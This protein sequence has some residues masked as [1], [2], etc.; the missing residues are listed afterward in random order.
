[1][2][3]NST[4]NKFVALLLVVLFTM[5]TSLMPGIAY[6]DSLSYPESSVLTETYKQMDIISWMAEEDDQSDFNEL[7]FYLDKWQMRNPTPTNNDLNDIA[8]G[9]EVFV[10]VGT[11][12]TILVSGDGEN[13]ILSNSGTSEYLSKVIYVNDR[14]IAIGDNGVVLTSP[15]GVNWTLGNVGE[16]ANLSGI[17]YGNGIYL[18]VSYWG[19]IYTSLDGVN[20]KNS[21]SNDYDYVGAAFGGGTFVIVDD[22]GYIVTSSDG[23]N[24]APGSSSNELNNIY[25][26]NYI[27]GSFFAVGEYN[28]VFSSYDGIDWIGKTIEKSSKYWSVNDITYGANGLVA[29][30]YQNQAPP[31][32]AYILS[33]QDGNTWTEK[34]IGN[35]TTNELFGAAYGKGKYVAVGEN[36][37]IVLSEDCVNW[38]LITKGVQNLRLSKVAYGNDTFLAVGP[39]GTVIR[40]D[41]GVTWE[42]MTVG[43]SDF[44]GVEFINGH[45]I[46]IGSD[47]TLMFSANGYDWRECFWKEGYKNA[48]WGVAYGNEEYVAVGEYGYIVTSTNGETWS[49]ERYGAPDEFFLQDAVFGDDKFV[50]VGYERV[51]YKTI[52]SVLVSTYGDNGRE[53]ERSDF[54]QQGWYF[55]KVIYAED[56]FTAV[57]VN[58]NYK[59]VVLTSKDGLDWSSKVIS[60]SKVVD[61]IWQD[62]V[63]VAATLQGEVLYS[64][65][66][67]NWSSIKLPVNELFGLTYGKGTFLAINSQGA[68]FQTGAPP[69]NPVESPTNQD[70]VTIEGTTLPDSDV[71]VFYRLDGGSREPAGTTSADSL[72]RFS[73]EVKLTEEGSY[74]F[75]AITL[76][77]GTELSETPPIYVTVDWT[78]PGVPTNIFAEGQ[79]T[80]HILLT[81]SSPGDV[82]VTKY[83]IYRDGTEVFH[84]S[85]D[86]NLRYVDGN[87][88]LGKTYL[89]QIVA[90]DRAGNR[91]EPASVTASTAEGGDT[92]P[93]TAPSNLHA[94]VLEGGS[95]NLTW[96][97]ADDNIGVAGYKVYRTQDEITQL[98]ATLD[99][100]TLTYRDQGL[101]SETSYDYQVTALDEAGNES[102]PSNIA[103]ITTQSIYLSQFT[104]QVQRNLTGQI[105]LGKTANLL[106]KGEKNRKAQVQVT[107]K[108][109]FDEEDNE[110]SEPIELE[111]IIELEEDQ[112]AQ[113]R[114]TYRGKFL[115]EE[116]IGEIISLKGMIFDEAG[117]KAEK[118]VA[119]LPLLVSG[120][121]KVTINSPGFTKGRIRV[122][123][124][125]LGY[126]V[127]KEISGEGTYYFDYLNPHDNYQIIVYNGGHRE[128]YSDVISIKPGLEI[129]KTPSL[130]QG[131]SLKVQLLDAGKPVQ[132]LKV[133]FVNE[134]TGDFVGSRE[135]DI[136]GWTGD[137]DFFQKGENVRVNLILDKDDTKVKVNKSLVQKFYSERSFKVYTLEPGDNAVAFDLTEVPK[138]LLTGRITDM[139]DGKAI[140]GVQVAISQVFEG[141]TYSA[142]VYS[143]KSGSYSF[144]IMKDVPVTIT[145]T[146]PLPARYAPAKQE[147]ITPTEE[148]C[149]KDFILEELHKYEIKARIYTKL[150][151]QDSFPIEPLDS[152]DA[153]GKFNLSIKDTRGSIAYYGKRQY[154]MVVYGKEG[155]IVQVSVDGGKLG[156]PARTEELVLGDPSEPQYVDFY[157]EQA[158]GRISGS[159]VSPSGPVGKWAAY[160]SFIND[161]GQREYL[162]TDEGKG[163]VPFSFCNLQPGLYEVSVTGSVGKEKVSGQG[164]FTLPDDNNREI[165][166]ELMPPGLFRGKDG[167]RIFAGSKEV[168]PGGVINYRVSYHNSS[169]KPVE[170]TALILEIPQDT[171]LVPG[172]VLLNNEQFSNDITVIPGGFEV[173]LGTV[174]AKQ[175]GTL[176]YQVK[177]ASSTDQEKIDV[178]A[179]IRHS[180]GQIEVLGT[181]R[182]NVVQLRM[183]APK[184]IKNHRIVITGRAPALSMVKVYHDNIILGEAQASPTG[185]WKTEVNLPEKGDPKWYQLM[186]K[187]WMEDGT[188]LTSK[189]SWVHYDSDSNVLEEIEF[190]VTCNKKTKTFD[191]RNGVAV[192]PYWISFPVKG[193]VQVSMKFNDSDSVYDVRVGMGSAT[194]VRSY[195]P[196][197]LKN[198]TFTTSFEATM[199]NLG[200]VYIAYKTKASPGTYK[201][202]QPTL[203]TLREMLPWQ[204]KDFEVL[205]IDQG[206]ESQQGK[207]VGDS[208]SKTASVAFSIPQSDKLTGEVKLSIKKVENYTPTQADLARAEKTGIPVY[209][210]N[211]D[212]SSLDNTDQ[213]I[214][215]ISGYIPESAVSDGEEIQALG[216]MLA[217]A[218]DDKEMLETLFRGSGILLTANAQAA[219]KLLQVGAQVIIKNPD[220]VLN[221][222]DWSNSLYEG[223]GVPDKFDQMAD[224]VGEAGNCSPEQYQSLKKQID[225]LARGAMF[226]EV[227]K[228]GLMLA[229]TLLAP[230][231]FGLST[232][233]MFAVGALGGAALDY[234]IDSRMEDLQNAVAEC[235]DDEDED[236]EDDEDNDESDD[237]YR[238]LVCDPRYIL[239]P[240]GYVYEAVEENRLEG[241]TAT[242]VEWANDKEYTVWDAEWYEQE[243]PQIT[244]WEGRYGW[245]VPSG[246]WQVIYEKDG[247]IT[248]Y[249]DKMEVPPAYTEVNVGLVSLSA[250]MIDKVEPAPGGSCIEVNFDKYIKDATIKDT[251]VQVTPANAE[252]IIEPISGTL[253]LVNPA[254]DPSD[255][256]T[257]L[258]RTVKFIPSEPLTIGSAYDVWVSKQ[259]QSYASVGMTE[260][261]RGTIIIPEAEDEGE[262]DEENE[263]P[264]DEDP[265][266]TKRNQK[267]SEIMP[268]EQRVEA[269][270]AAQKVSAFDEG[271]TLDIP[272]GAFDSSVTLIIRKTSTLATLANG[273]TI[274]SPVFEI[275]TSGVLPKKPIILRIKFD[276]A[277]IDDLR[278]LGIYRQNDLNKSQWIYKGGVID[279]EAGMITIELKDFSNYAVM[280]YERKFN[281]LLGHWSSK[282]VDVLI[283]RHM[284]K[285]VSESEFQPKRNITRAELVKLLVEVMNIASGRCFQENAS[286]ASIFN[287]VSPNDWYFRYVQI[288]AEYGIVKGNN[289]KFRPGDPVTREEI[290]TMI[291]RLLGQETDKK[292]VKLTYSDTGQISQWALNAVASMEEL[293]IMTGITPDKF[294]PGKNATRAESAVIILRVMEQLGLITEKDTNLKVPGG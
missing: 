150:A 112:D 235:E 279:T 176:R 138:S 67:E 82:D 14:F 132:G 175:E 10:A 212:Y 93:P 72:G 104:W 101:L 263:E 143:D 61:I 89:Y 141:R 131:A 28:S 108:Y 9:N 111:K 63:Y 187:A 50:I 75:T 32:G 196:A 103:A 76:L 59:G 292:G 86:Q 162:Q 284:V 217:S 254:V 68:I 53:W 191:P 213:V 121:I 29:V 74:A 16:D 115:V 71:E 185:F 247:Y 241:V 62:G 12:G 291:N 18:A 232:V 164:S 134:Q 106:L 228:W 211:W 95:V 33:S 4:F 233:A 294:A 110:L 84:V 37:T 183:D 169:D 248:G 280:T 270:R 274:N 161:N 56:K 240:S 46:A 192:F 39:A 99:S 222:V 283:S 8:F 249:S 230:A 52:T 257:F 117:N 173:S 81:W 193:N 155:D 15:D 78:A 119:G 166:V 2:K 153:A 146:V 100:N 179:S 246:L 165:K 35:T 120:K 239:D 201:K 69:L 160:L 7:T 156:L 88:S 113:G 79:D 262:D 227:G 19:V 289:G 242:V 40:S 149:I 26:I 3:K 221:A 148:T 199:E 223:F 94:S 20:W 266:P 122:K 126:N 172:S 278:K 255:D 276:T 197:V 234:T 47:G 190:G 207:T 158:A 96:Q 22:S 188:V 90:E 238:R 281:D 286:A 45:F 44:L 91:S 54:R 229:G 206:D 265:V 48:L 92:V 73:L 30:G 186:T 42:K 70:K 151:E 55:S 144:N 182:V 154:P 244:D 251:T 208:T 245:D 109:W 114:G 87:V 85:S 136:N 130:P 171:E 64:I 174:K 258:S 142:Q 80:R 6:A 225:D 23:I 128:I 214:V 135:S 107:Y 163:D 209:G 21:F 145:T 264:I 36:G 116:G 157:L 152:F 66:G 168:A 170:N 252:D 200:P 177:L 216:L 224:L 51:N 256:K 11:D 178:R 260:D 195:E 282:D 123:N 83:L 181:N 147:V 231:T 118:L 140:Q 259:V 98:I 125:T 31:S 261:Y 124:D 184:E 203:E 237:Y 27:N 1:M 272:E 34:L 49:Y 288:A 253:E 137:L 205:N 220:G 129:E 204:M 97:A 285:G 189:D 77:N 202:P 275:D 13:W 17:T 219:Q 269:G 43:K 139:K 236:E 133:G 180:N 271:I 167:N 287:D 267:T 194:P 293:G 24:F 218:M 290:S 226:A 60:N 65:D 198:G 159:L 57:G 250:P 25:N 277:D 273:F 268:D 105:V 102:V 41:D 127:S 58:A 215:N 38:R 210:F 5:Q 243:N